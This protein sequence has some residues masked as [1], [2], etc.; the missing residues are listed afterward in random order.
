MNY[1]LW[2]YH[3]H[4]DHN[5]PFLPP[6][7]PPATPTKNKL[8][9]HCFQFF[10]DITVVPR[11]IKDNGYVK[12]GGWTMCIMVYSKMVNTILSIAQWRIQWYQSPYIAFKLLWSFHGWCCSLIYHSFPERQT[13]KYRCLISIS[14]FQS[15]Y[16]L[17]AR[18][19]GI[20]IIV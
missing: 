3:V 10:L 20:I 1:E 8:H 5:A 9:N 12:F 17:N 18:L 6:P 14:R 13:R 2:I 11:E 4:I 19:Q 7:P 15:V 16:E